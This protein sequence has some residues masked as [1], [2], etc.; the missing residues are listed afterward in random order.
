MGAVVSSVGI[1][2]QGNTAA[3]TSLP[4]DG[5]AHTYVITIVPT[6]ASG[7]PVSGSSGALANPVSVALTESGGTGYASLVYNGLAAGTSATLKSSNDTLAVA[8]TG[9]GSAGYAIAVAFSAGGIPTSTLV[10]APLFVTSSHLSGGTVTLA[11]TPQSVTLQ[12][13][14]QGAPAGVSY[15]GSGASCP[16]LPSG[17]N[18]QLPPVLGGSVSGGGAAATVTITGNV[19]PQSTSGCAV[20]VADNLGTTLTF[21]VLLPAGSA[22]P[23]SAAAGAQIDPLHYSSGAPVPL[24][25]TQGG[26]PVTALTLHQSAGPVTLTV[27]EPNDIS[28]PLVSAPACSGIVTVASSLTQGTWSASA[29]G[30]LSGTVVLVP[31]AAGSCTVTISD[32]N[33][34]SQAIAL[35]AVSS[36]SI[37]EFPA[38]LSQ[39]SGAL[40][41]NQGGVAYGVTLG[42]DGNLWV[43][44]QGGKLAKITAS[45][46]LTEYDPGLGRLYGI[47]AGSDGNLWAVYGGIAVISTSGTVLQTYAT[48]NN[49]TAG[50]PVFPYAIVAGADGALWYSAGGNF[51]DGPGAIGRITTAG[52]PSFACYIGA[53]TLRQFG[54]NAGGTNFY[55]VG[56]DPNNSSGLVVNEAATST[57]GNGACAGAVVDQIP[58]WEQWGPQL[59]AGTLDGN[60]WFI[61]AGQFA[62]QGPYVSQWG[63][64]SEYSPPQTVVAIAGGPDG[65]LWLALSSGIERLST[66]Q[67]QTAVFNKTATGASLASTPVA[68]APGPGGNMWFVEANGTFG[69]VTP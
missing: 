26:A 67:L 42:P 8:Y 50:H 60:V 38:M 49:V 32:G 25:V 37:T 58:N 66:N 45:G 39:P 6:D 30:S 31:T 63:A 29:M 52:T 68:I 28:A 23:S 2:S 56:N 61:T 3:Y 59:L 13:T 33:G 57:S 15:A 12:A 35:S 10:I 14:E 17:S 51:N 53:G 7:N 41:P 16:A 34:G 43:T 65:N 20:T 40:G 4:A 22:S 54:T 44:E 5:A 64:W 9:G 55:T 46:T 21:P 36:G 18:P 48:F 19:A 69:Y 1:G 27:L 62:G 24:S 11:S 47:A